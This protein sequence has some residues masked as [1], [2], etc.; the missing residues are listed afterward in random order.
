MLKSRIYLHLPKL[1]KAEIWYDEEIFTTLKLNQFLSHLADSE[2]HKNP[3]NQDP[4][5]WF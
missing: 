3:R 4:E 1:A 5:E 2:K